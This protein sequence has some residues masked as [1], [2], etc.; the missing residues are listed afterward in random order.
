MRVGIVGIGS[1]L[2]GNIVTN[3]DLEKT[4]E[5]TD[6]WIIERTGI[7]NRRKADSTICCSDLG[8]KA[9]RIAIQNAN[10]DP[11]DIDLILLTSSSPDQIFP[12]TACIIQ[13]KIGAINAA[14]FD[15]QAACSGFVYAL[16]T[17]VQYIAGGLYKNILVVGSE[18]LSKVTDWEDRNTCILFGD[19]AG[20]VV[21]SEVEV[22]GVLSSLLGTDGSGAHLLELPAGGTKEPATFETVKNRRHYIKMNG[23]EV[24]KFAVKIL[25]DSTKKVVE[26]AG[27]SLEDIDFIVPH[28]A[29]IRI[30]RA[31]MKR[32]KFPIERVL[33]NLDKYGNMSAASIP[34]AIDEAFKAGKIRKGN[35][36]VLV[37]FGAGLTWGANLL[38]WSLQ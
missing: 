28:Q 17:A 7:A 14:A 6:E 25:E 20:A 9:A 27:L 11:K 8:A 2:P 3:Y 31:A 36:I 22:G 24:F 16:T 18:V 35:K 4:V 10:L 19:G 26:K 15:I 21:L 33:L 23:N 29:N 5:T 37:G 30:I 1:Y 13:D 34:V 12:A 38:E 32:L